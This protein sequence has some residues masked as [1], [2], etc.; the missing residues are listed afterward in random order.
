MLNAPAQELRRLRQAADLGSEDI[1]QFGLGVRPTVGERAFQVVPHAL[2]RVKLRSIGRK[3]NEME[4]R[5]ARQQFLNGVTPMDRPVV[6]KDED[7]AGDLAKQMPEE[8]GELFA[9]DVVLV[10]LAVQRAT[11]ALRTYGDPRDG[12]DTVVAIA[13]RN[14]W[15]P[16]NRTPCFEHR[17]DEKK[18]GF[19]YENEVGTQ[20]EGVFFTRGQTCRF[21]SSMAASLRSMARSSGFWWLHPSSCRSFPT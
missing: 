12:G 19:V 20:P 15:R 1:H 11:E 6:Q 10:E 3:G 5:R 17:R 14:E 7:M 4:A 21:Q 18:P 16:A 9:L 2:V 13:M 8:R